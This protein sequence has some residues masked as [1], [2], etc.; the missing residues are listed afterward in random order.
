MWTGCTPEDDAM[1]QRNTR[2]WSLGRGGNSTLS[3]AGRWRKG[4]R[5]SSSLVGLSSTTSSCWRATLASI[6]AAPLLLGNT[7]TSHPVGESCIA[8]V[9]SSGGDNG[10]ATGCLPR[11]TL[12]MHP[13]TPFL[14]ANRPSHDPIGEAVSTIV[15]VGRGGWYDGH[16]HQHR[17]DWLRASHVVDPAAP[18]L[19][20]CFP[21]VWRV[22]CTIE[23]INW[24]DRPRRWRRARRWL[25]WWGCWW[26]GWR[27]CRWWSR[28]N[29]WRLGGA[30]DSTG[31]A[32][33]LLLHW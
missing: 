24:T 23:R 29:Y 20:I 21:H 4:Q 8:I 12:S 17:G 7:P 2:P 19:L 30:T 10:S 25:R 15:W 9:W 16:W 14:L 33:I 5:C 18:R 13:A 1:R 31:A 6:R 11:A 32:T 22:H 27:R 26:R 3:I 28:L